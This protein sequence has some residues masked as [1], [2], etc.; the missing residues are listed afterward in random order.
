M[1]KR[2]KNTFKKDKTIETV[3][4]WGKS[5]WENIAGISMRFPKKPEE[6]VDW[7]CQ[8]KILVGSEYHQIFTNLGRMKFNWL[9]KLWCKLNNL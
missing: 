5:H 6:P 8:R 3:D 1:R 2:T 7:V 9:I 4:Y